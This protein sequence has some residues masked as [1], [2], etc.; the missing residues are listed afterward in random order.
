MAPAA[1]LKKTRGAVLL[2]TTSGFRWLSEVR[3]RCLMCR[4]RTRVPDQWYGDSLAGLGSAR[5]AERRMPKAKLVN[6]GK[7]EFMA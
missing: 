3:V 4:A 2:S 5:V 6:T 1:A 7:S